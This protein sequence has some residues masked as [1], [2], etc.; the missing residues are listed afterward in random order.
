[1]G[2]QVSVRLAIVFLIVVAGLFTLGCWLLRGLCRDACPKRV[3][4]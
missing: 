4:K 1:M 3:P 2:V